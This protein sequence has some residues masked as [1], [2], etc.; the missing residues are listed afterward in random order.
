MNAIYLLI[1]TAWLAVSGIII[2]TDYLKY[3]T[4]Y[5]TPSTENECNQND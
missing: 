3:K 4:Y 5:N 1:A 2:I